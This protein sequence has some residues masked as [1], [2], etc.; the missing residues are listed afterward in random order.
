[1]TA[2]NLRNGLSEADDGETTRD[3]RRQ[4]LWRSGLGIEPPAWRPDEEAP[5]IDEAALREMVE[6]RLSDEE[7][8]RIFALSLLFRKWRDALT[9]LL[10]DNYAAARRRDGEV[11]GPDSSLAHPSESTP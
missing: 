4:R 3:S 10:E 6:G 7:S 8:N 9:R 2:E 5:P 11:S 1:M